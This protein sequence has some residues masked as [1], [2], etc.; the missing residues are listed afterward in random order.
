MEDLQRLKEERTRLAAAA[1]VPMDLAEAEKRDVTEDEA[2]AI[3][4]TLGELAECRTKIEKIE[5]SLELRRRVL[6]AETDANRPDPQNLGQPSI[7][8]GPVTD[9]LR[10]PAR[11]HRF[12]GRLRN[13]TQARCGDRGPELA[14]AFGRI[15]LASRGHHPSV[16]WCNQHASEY[17]T[18]QAEGSN[19]LGGYLVWPEIN[20]VIIDLKE[21][22]GVFRRESKVLPMGSESLVIPRR[23][24]GLTAYYIGENTEA[25]ESNATWDQVELT[26]KKF[27][28]LVKISSE[29]SEDAIVSMGDLIAREI[30]YAF[31]DKEDE[32]GFNGDGTSTYGGIYGITAKIND[33]NHAASIITSLEQKPADTIWG[34]FE[35]MVGKLPSYAT[36]NAKWYFHKAWANGSFLRLENAAGGNTAAMLAAG[37]PTACMGYPVVYTQVLSSTITDQ[38]SVIVGLFGDLAL[39]TTMGDRR[40]TRIL[41]SNERYMESDQV[42]ILATTR[43]DIQAHD[44]GDGTDAGPIIALKTA[45][46]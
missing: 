33:G 30:A 37:I 25:T 46:S 10:E 11:A 40:G 34:E 14:H 12:E 16:E 24:G 38:T 42:G 22:R 2:K 35:E 36:A 26:P 5:A 15:V 41:A 1:K 28:I 3:N 44:L 39:A 29:L 8:P 7:A 13:F 31:A 18:A 32:C 19:L 45:A 27:A 6:D 23:T 20:R 17:R 43:Y 9:P 21:E 4:V